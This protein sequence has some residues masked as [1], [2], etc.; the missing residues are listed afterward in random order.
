MLPHLIPLISTP[1]NNKFWGEKAWVRGCKYPLTPT[2][3]LLERYQALAEQ[4]EQILDSQ[5]VEVCHITW[6]QDGVPL[7]NLRVPLPTQEPS[8]LPSV[9]HVVCDLLTHVEQTAL[10]NADTTGVCVHEL[11]SA[12]YQHTHLLP[13]PQSPSSH[14]CSH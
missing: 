1:S 2:V 13:P 14:S 7:S 11:H 9:R 8:F 4:Y 10:S 6:S 5:E 12:L 3:P